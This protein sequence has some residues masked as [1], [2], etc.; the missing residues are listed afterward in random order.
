LDPLGE[1]G[2]VDPLGERGLVDP[3]GERGLG[4]K[5]A[6]TPMITTDGRVIASLAVR[7]EVVAE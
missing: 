5:V 1:S 3:L 7:E 2:L 4:P 6:A